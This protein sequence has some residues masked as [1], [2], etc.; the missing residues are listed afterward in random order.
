MQSLAI[1]TIKILSSELVVKT[2]TLNNLIIRHIIARELGSLLNRPHNK[3]LDLGCG[4]GSLA[5][6]FLPQSYIGIDINLAATHLA[7]RKKNYHFRQMDATHLTFRTESFN[8]VLVVGVLHHL[9]TQD[10]V[11]VAAEMARVL[12]PDCH[13]LVIEAITPL[14]KFNLAGWIVRRLDAGDYIRTPREY[15]TTLKNYFLIERSYTAL[16]GVFDY[17]VFVLKNKKSAKK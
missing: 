8:A 16:G 10:F 2:L 7:Q 14:W 15:Q 13:A 4:T 9:S 3:I 11:K 6:L 5:D 17:A 1:E 12:K